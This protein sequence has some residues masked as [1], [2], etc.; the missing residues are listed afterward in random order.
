MTNQSWRVVAAALAVVLAVLAGATIAFV[1][2]PGPGASR[3]ARPAQLPVRLAVRE[4]HRRSERLDPGVALP[5]REPGPERVRLA[6]PVADAGPDRPGDDHRAQARSAR[7]I[8]RRRPAVHRVLE[9]WAGHDQ[10]AAEGHQPAGHDPHVPARRE[11]GHQVRRS[12]QHD[13]HGHDDVGARR[14]AGQPRRATGCSR[15]RSS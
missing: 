8:E 2:A 7:P 3:L 10:G 9:R 11:Q 12:G 6:D 5:D 14:L 13:D 15:R 1:I 4:R